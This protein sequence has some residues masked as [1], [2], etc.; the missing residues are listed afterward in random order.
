MA[1]AALAIANARADAERDAV[2]G[3]GS[4]AISLGPRRSWALNAGLLAVV[5]GAGIVT[6]VAG[7]ASGAA[8]AG[9]LVASLVV[10]LGVVVGR[11]RDSARRERAWELE[12]IGVGLLAAA[13][14]A[15]MPLGS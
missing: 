9:A 13:W 14:L 7:R 11:G 2:A 5:I 8:L 4:V 1:G 10:V 3:V 12:A 6:L 15:G